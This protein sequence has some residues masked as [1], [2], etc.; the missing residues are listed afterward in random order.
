MS[1]VHVPPHGFESVP[2]EP[3]EYGRIKVERHDGGVYLVTWKD[4][5]E[6]SEHHAAQLGWELIAGE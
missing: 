4:A 3:A 2:F 6:V 1:E 5:I